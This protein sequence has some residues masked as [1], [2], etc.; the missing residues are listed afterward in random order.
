MA[1]QSVRL[2]SMVD[3][4]TYDDGAF[5][6]AIETDQPI[7]AGPPVDGND[8]TRLDDLAASLATIFPVGAIYI[9]TLATNPGTLLGIGTW[10]QVAQGEV[11]IGEA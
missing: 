3:A 5:D 7:K 9:S 2:G 6:S 1:R 10:V 8:V 4:I 11:L